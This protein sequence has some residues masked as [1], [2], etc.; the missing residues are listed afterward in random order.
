MV[1]G[2]L[3]SKVDRIWDAFWTGGMS[4]PLEIIEQ[5]TYLLFIR[6]LDDLQT[7]EE[8]K[9]EAT[10]KPAERPFFRE[11]QEHLRWSELKSLDAQTMHRVI[12]E[13]SSKRSGSA[14]FPHRMLLSLSLGGSPE[15]GLSR[16]R[17]C[18]GVG[19]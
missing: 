11:D 10:G 18:V 6:R 17:K 13:A 4:N 2:E 8:R 5:I 14:Q 7:V 15:P 12:S 9:A 1:T 19:T 16:S 3:K